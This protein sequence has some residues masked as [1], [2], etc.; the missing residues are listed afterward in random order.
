MNLFTLKV[1]SSNGIYYDGTTTDLLIPATDGSFGIQ[2]NHENMV[3]AIVP[4]EI[5]I[6]K[7]DGSWLTAAISSGFAD[8][9]DNTVTVLADTVESP[10]EIDQRR[11][12]E[13]LERAEERMRQKQSIQEYHASQAAIARAMNR[14]KTSRDRNWH[15]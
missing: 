8:I 3:V 14:L 15:L 9:R 5:H 11:A 10:E 2:A 1:F 7:E 4:G 13:A 6:K 12:Q